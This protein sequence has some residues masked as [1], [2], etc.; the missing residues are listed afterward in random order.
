[1]K[2]FEKMSN[3]GRGSSKLQPEILS[4]PESHLKNLHILLLEV[5]ISGVQQFSS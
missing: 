4:S 3:C 1:M 5:C 2:V